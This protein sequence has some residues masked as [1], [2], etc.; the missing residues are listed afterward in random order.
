MQR[1]KVKMCPIRK[2]RIADKRE[3]SEKGEALLDLFKMGIY[4]SA[5][6]PKPVLDFG[7][8]DQPSS[9]YNY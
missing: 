9:V 5:G 3:A 7:M 1:K 6:R 8:I 4:S 2:L